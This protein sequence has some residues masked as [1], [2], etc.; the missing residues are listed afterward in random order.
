MELSY[1]R[2]AESRRCYGFCVS[3]QSNHCVGRSECGGCL[4]DRSGADDHRTLAKA[5][6]DFQV[7]RIPVTVAVV[8]E[9]VW[10]DAFL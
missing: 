9:Y 3:V 1:L 4:A 6:T 10:A 5:D 7:R 8:G 2:R